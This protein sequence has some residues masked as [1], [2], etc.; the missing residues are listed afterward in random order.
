MRPG[1]PAQP[2][3]NVAGV[4][5]AVANGNLNLKLPASRQMQA[6][7]WLANA[8]RQPSADGT[9]GL[10]SHSPNMSHAT[11]NGILPLATPAGVLRTTPTMAQM[12]AAGQGRASPANGNMSISPLMQHASPAPVVATYSS[13]PQSSS[14]SRPAS[15]ASLALSPPSMQQQLASPSL[16][17]QHMVAQGIQGTGY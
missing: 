14:P 7:Q 8:H 1:F 10:P 16:Q 5:G 2:A 13:P 15:Q 11:A 17:Q 4:N 6:M 3:T 12:M 9:N